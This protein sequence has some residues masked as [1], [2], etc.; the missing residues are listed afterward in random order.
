MDGWGAGRIS[1]I[2]FWTP[3]VG[4]LFQMADFSIGLCD[5]SVREMLEG[6]RVGRVV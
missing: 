1:R 2:G 3:I 5:C 6:E 4:G